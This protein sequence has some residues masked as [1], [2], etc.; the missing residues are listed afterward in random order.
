MQRRDRLDAAA[1]A[2]MVLLCVLWGLQQA[3]VKIGVQQ[4]LPPVLQ[5]LLRSVIAS[6]LLCAWIAAR[7]GAGPLRGLLRRSPRTGPALLLALVFGVEFILIYTGL[8]LTSASRAVLFLYTAPFFTALGAHWFLPAERLR[9]AQVAGLALAF[10]GIAAVFAEGVLRGG[11]SLAGDAMCAAAGVLWGGSSVILKASPGLRGT[12]PALLL[13][14]QVG[15][16]VPVLLLGA[17]A[18][19]EMTRWPDASAVAWI[20]LAYQGVIVAFASYLAWTWLLLAY[21]AA[22]VAGFTFLTPLFGIMGGALLLG[23]A[24]SPA[25]LIGLAAIAIGLRLLNRGAGGG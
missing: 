10:A 5:A 4:G 1:V 15:G 6:A 16:S 9:A 19:G 8:R 20:G 2:L 14:Y 17:L 18:M 11:G 23:E 22:K 13:L 3:V 21:P 25:L 24:L 7:Q 12:D